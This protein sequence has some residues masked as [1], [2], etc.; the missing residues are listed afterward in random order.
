MREDLKNLQIENVKNHLLFFYN[1]DCPYCAEIWPQV[2]LLAEQMEW[3][4]RGINASIMDDEGV[5]QVPGL[6]AT[7]Y[8]DRIMLGRDCVTYLKGLIANER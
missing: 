6:F 5:P 1:D 3:G 2:R 8:P 7:A 4:V